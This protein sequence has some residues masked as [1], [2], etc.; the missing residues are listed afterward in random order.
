LGDHVDQ[1]AAFSGQ[2]HDRRKERPLVA[3]RSE[4]STALF[5]VAITFLSNSALAKAE[6][7]G[8]AGG[9]YTPMDFG[10][11]GNAVIVLDGAITVNSAVLT[12]TKSTPFRCPSDVGKAIV[13]TGAGQRFPNVTAAIGD[14]S[15]LPLALVSTIASCQ[16]S[17]RVTLAHRA[18]FTV[19]NRWTAFGTDDTAA[20]RACV[21]A[22]TNLGGRC[23]I[24]DGVTF[25]AS[26][27]ATMIAVYN[28][29][30]KAS[31]SSGVID[32]RGTIIVAPQGTNTPGS[33]DRLF[34][35][36]NH[37]SDY[38][39]IAAA[40]PTGASSFRAANASDAAK[41]APGRLDSDRR[42]LASSG[43]QR[44]DRL[45]SGQERFRR[46]CYSDAADEDDLA[47][48]RRMGSTVRRIGVGG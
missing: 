1:P 27:T 7:S 33:N 32:G 4:L 14:K 38:Y 19:A 11:K 45:G 24:T 47:R 18:F 17:N 26:N 15:E 9:A 29:S 5:A 30:G 8:G 20:L 25:M 3:K 12:T 23:T 10:A 44:V 31:I 21:N 13:I 6:S 2:V 36:I 35:A 34:F 22:G 46:D 16:A 40:I 41:L 42:D 48:Y 37:L 43:K 39:E 28:K